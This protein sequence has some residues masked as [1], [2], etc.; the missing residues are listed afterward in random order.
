MITLTASLEPPDI[1]DKTETTV[2]QDPRD[3]IAGRVND[4]LVKRMAA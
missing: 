4:D 2:K 3:I 1:R